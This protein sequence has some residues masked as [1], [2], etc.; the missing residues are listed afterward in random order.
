MAATPSVEVTYSVPSRASAKN[1]SNRWH[2]LGGTPSGPT[3]WEALFAAIQT[4][5]IA[6]ISTECSLVRFDGF[7]AGSDVAAHS[8]N[9]SDSGTAEIGEGGSAAVSGFC[10]ALIRWSTDQKT[11]KNHPIY[12]FSY[13]HGILADAASS[14]GAQELSTGQ[15]LAPLEA[16]ASGWIAGYSDGT[17]TYTRAGPNGA[18]AL[19]SFVDPYI[20]E[21]E[22]SPT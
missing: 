2:F 16:L 1:V 22:L 19:D 21:H 15:S 6:C 14:P 20:R 11:S 18:A 4:D 3:A 10:C 8:Q 17:N 13:V 12:L 5:F 7:P 9:V